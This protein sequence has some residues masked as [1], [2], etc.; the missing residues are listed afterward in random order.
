MPVV[1]HPLLAEA[2]H[3]HGV[4]VP[5]RLLGQLLDCHHPV[6]RDFAEKLASN[7]HDTAVNAITPFR[8]EGPCPAAAVLEDRLRDPI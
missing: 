7:N 4:L 3:P 2:A 6:Y 1:V 8:E 5:D